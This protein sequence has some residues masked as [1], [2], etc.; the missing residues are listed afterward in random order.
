MKAQMTEQAFP[1]LR[2][3]QHSLWAGKNRILQVS[4]HGRALA[5]TFVTVVSS[6][7]TKGHMTDRQHFSLLQRQSQMLAALAPSANPRPFR[8]KEV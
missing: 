4:I 3:S 8:L 6:H 2:V 7:V 5:N 1:S